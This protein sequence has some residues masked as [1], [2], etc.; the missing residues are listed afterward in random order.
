MALPMERFQILLTR[1]Q[2]RALETQ[3]QVEDR[4]VAELVREAVDEKFR[5]PTREQRLAALARMRKR[6]R[7][8]TGPAPTPEEIN[9]LIETRYRDIPSV[10]Q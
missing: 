6:R 7:R 4:S 9:A 8:T 1:E 5:F 3:A 10:P 2:R